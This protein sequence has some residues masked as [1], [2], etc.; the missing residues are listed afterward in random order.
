MHLQTRHTQLHTSS[1]VDYFRRN[2]DLGA[3]VSLVVDR[4]N[5]YYTWFSEFN[6]HIRHTVSFFFK[7]FYMIDLILFYV[8]WYSACMSVRMSR[9][10]ELELQIVVSCYVVLG[11]ES[12]S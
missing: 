12:G 10:L 6:P 3:K 1:Y 8:H 2:F 4:A 5:A 9:S 7:H 11:I